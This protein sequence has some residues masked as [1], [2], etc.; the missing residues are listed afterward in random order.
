MIIWLYNGRYENVIPLVG[1]FHTLLVYLKILY[2][3]CNCL[4]LQDWLVDAGAIQQGSVCK[5][6]RRQTL[7]ER[8]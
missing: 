8:N 1:G 7:P 6:N 4:G 2:K 5:G 3:K